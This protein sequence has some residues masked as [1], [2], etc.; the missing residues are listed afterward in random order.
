MSQ[1]K[2]V[3]HLLAAILADALV[4]R[5]AEELLGWGRVEWAADRDD[6]ASQIDV[7]IFSQPINHI[8]FLFLN[9]FDLDRFRRGN[10]IAWAALRIGVGRLLARLG[11]FGNLKWVLLGAI[12]IR[13]R[14]TI[15]FVDWGCFDILLTFVL[16][17]TLLRRQDSLE[18][19]DI[20]LSFVCFVHFFDSLHIELHLVR[21]VLC[22]TPLETLVKGLLQ[23][24]RAHMWTASERRNLI[25]LL[26]LLD[27]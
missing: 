17:I 25:D 9:I 26:Y 4:T 10:S 13:R 22:Y 8:V 19:C 2:L 18:R 15:F 11:I 24:L 23:A 14:H 1:T 20:K 5:R 7:E 16:I 6:G 3:I 12:L 21:R 27:R